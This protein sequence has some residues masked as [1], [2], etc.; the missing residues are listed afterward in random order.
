MAR[1]SITE[2]GWI[3]WVFNFPKEDVRSI[4]GKQDLIA[5]YVKTYLQ[6]IRD[7]GVFTIPEPK[8]IWSK[9]YQPDDTHTSIN[10]TVNLTFE[11]DDE[12]YPPPVRDLAVQNSGST[13]QFAAIQTGPTPQPPPKPAN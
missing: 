6:L 2:N 8:L 1:V 11:Y 12:K 13:N 10:L 3:E 7:F 5:R 4:P 9:E